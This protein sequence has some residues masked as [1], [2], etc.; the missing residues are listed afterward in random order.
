MFTEDQKTRSELQKHQ[1]LANKQHYVY[2]QSTKSN[3][4]NNHP[5]PVQSFTLS[6]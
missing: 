4:G 2:I 6:Q 3:E 1:K 5:P